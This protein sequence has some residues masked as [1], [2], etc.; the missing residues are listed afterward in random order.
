MQVESTE[1]IPPMP[2]PGTII[3]NR[4][5]A[6][7]LTQRELADALGATQGY[8]WRLEHDEAVPSDSMVARLG[9]VLDINPDEFHAMIQRPP[10]DI[11]AMLRRLDA[12]GLAELRAYLTAA[13]EQE[14]NR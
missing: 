5:K 9:E 7:G 6:L 4:R 12:N 13:T 1:R 11:R 8:T 2:T 10:A 3:A 14:K